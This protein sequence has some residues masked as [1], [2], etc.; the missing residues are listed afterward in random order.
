MECGDPAADSKL[1]EKVV[2]ACPA[3]GTSV[4]LPRGVE[5][6]RNVTRP[7]AVPVAALTVAVKVTVP[8]SVIVVG[9]AATVVAVAVDDC[10]RSGL[11]AGATKAINRPE[12]LAIRRNEALRKTEGAVLTGGSFGGGLLTFAGEKGRRHFRVVLY[13]RQYFILMVLSI[14]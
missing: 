11:T 8:P 7:V 9:N 5:P 14:P 10:A 2:W 4:P 3:M 13:S 1:V 12:N 6:S